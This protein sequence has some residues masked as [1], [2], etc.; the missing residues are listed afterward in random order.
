MSELDGSEGEFQGEWWYRRRWLRAVFTPLL[1][2]TSWKY[3]LWRYLNQPLETR[4]KKAER[5][6][7][8]IRKRY[9][10]PRSGRQELVGRDAEFEQVMLSVYYHVVRDPEV[11]KVTPFPP[12]KLFIV[13]GGSG[14]GKT[15]FA[16]AIQREAFEVGVK[17]GLVLNYGSLKPEQVYSMWYG[18][19]AQRLS[20]FFNNAFFRPSIILIDEFQAFGRKFTSM[21]ET[22]MEEARV[23]TVFLEKIDELQKREYR[24][25]VL[26]S[27]T[28]YESL[29]ETLRR[30]GLVGTI[31]LDAGMTKGMLVE[32]SKRWCERYKLKVDPAQVVEV[33]EDAVRALG[34]TELTPADVV[35]AFHLVVNIRTEELRKG[36]I[37]RVLPIG[38][39]EA[40][41]FSEVVEGIT[42][43]DFRLAARKLKSY[44]AEER[45]E[46]AKR[47]VLRIKPRESYKDVGG[48]HGVKEEVIKEISLAL[49]R[50]LSL[51]A[52]YMP[53]KGF[54]F[55][56]PPGTGKTLL[57]RSI[58]GENEVWF[59]NVNGPSILQGKYGDPEKT[60]RNIFEDARK[61]APAIVYFDEIDSIAPR[62][63]TADP[64]LDRVTSQLLMEIDGFVPLTGVVVI[65]STNRLEAL[66]P[67]L[68]ERFTRQF[69]FTYPKNRQEKCEII[70][71]HLRKYVDSLSPEVTVDSVYDVLEKKVL[72]PRRIA[73][74]IDDANRLR[75]KEIEAARRLAKALGEGQ[76]KVEAV[77]D[78]FKQDIERLFK[79]RGLDWSDPRLLESVSK[80]DPSNY[81]LTLFHFEEALSRTSDES[82]EEARQLVE[83]SVRFEVPEVG[84][85]Y[86]MVA[87]G[88]GGQTGGLIVA[89]EV[90]V[91][92]N[93][94]GEVIVVG[95]EVGESIR[96]SAQDAFVHINSLSDWRFR[97][98]DVYIELVTPA[99]GMEKQLVFPGAERAPVSGP[100]AGL[101]IGIAMLSAFLQVKVDPTVV[102]TGAITA[103][104]E[105]WPVGGLDYRG[106]GKI[107]AA[108]ADK[109]VKRFVIPQYNYE[110]MREQGTVQL[111]ERKGVQVLPVRTFI[112]AAS[113]CLAE[114]LGQEELAVKLKT[115]ELT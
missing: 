19:S 96:A 105:V 93:G 4:R 104:G 59:Y 27:T 114:P 106:M 33:L 68:L 6:A 82:V 12:P 9:D 39:G 103:K 86:A 35:N 83:S 30:R 29:L 56:G 31:D 60:I 65:G 107:E 17:H 43:N 32:I 89:V 79:L 20:E 34:S 97:D 69:E 15:F 90:I 77:K 26:I 110:K 7:R 74:V 8:K 40:Q 48:L 72:S 44:A 2:L 62:R 76:E 111:L 71:I 63:G 113:Y 64:I 75:V 70:E 36:I 52:R 37:S 87:L 46:A 25:V 49:N 57:A 23:Q 98:Y 78:I 18:Q 55:F 14:S 24:T 61:N 80:I 94:R 11:R 81:K 84:K 38:R 112:E 88:E 91:N 53:P 16:E 1:Y 45:T 99:K 47:S 109:Y 102:L 10:F 54:V 108:M 50:E 85:S 101:A 95:S 58:A 21:T 41:Q 42:L 28:E 66:D 115:N 22:G 100:S 51:K 73:N 67:A 92:P 13:K 5:E 3:R